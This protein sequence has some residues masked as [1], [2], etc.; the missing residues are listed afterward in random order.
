[1]ESGL[2]L[3]RVLVLDDDPAV[4]RVIGDMIEDIGLETVCVH[5]DAEA[6]S[7]LHTPQAFKAVILD[8]NLGKGTTGFDIARFARQVIPEINVIYVT[9]DWSENSFRAFGVPHS[10]FLTKPLHHGDLLSALGETALSWRRERT[11]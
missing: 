6:Y 1:M 8:V 2:T 9:G 7:A 11:L 5:G 3:G 10:H 4:C